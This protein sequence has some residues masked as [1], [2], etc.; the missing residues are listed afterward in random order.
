MAYGVKNIAMLTI[1]IALGALVLALVISARRPPAQQAPSEQTTSVRIITLK[2]EEFIPRVIG[3]GAVYPARTWNAVAQV[4]GRL[5]YVHPKFKRGNILKSG[6]EI[7][8]INPQDYELALRETLANIEAGKAKLN[9]LKVQQTNIN[10]SLVIERR[11]VDIKQ[12]ELSR[13]EGLVKRGTISAASIEVVQRELLAQRARVQDLENNLRL[14]PTQISAQEE[15]I[16]VFQAKSETARLNLKRTS[17]RLP[18]DA[19]IADGKAEATQF[20][21]VGTSLGSADGLDVAE[22]SAQIPLTQ[23]RKFVRLAMPQGFM[24]PNLNDQLFEGLVE[25]LGWT[26]RVRVGSA[27]DET[28]WKARFVRTSD[29]ID[30]NTRTLGAIVAVDQPY[31]NIRPGIRPPLVK[32]MFV[33]VEIE[34]RSLADQIIIPRSALHGGTVWIANKDNRLDIRPIQVKLIQGDHALIGSGITAGERLVIGDLSPAISGMLLKVVE[35]EQKNDVI[36][37]TDEVV[38]DTN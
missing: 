1:P 17:I 28:S 27:D 9:E 12:A 20:V 23:F 25:K 16:L 5:E 34:S 6:T 36:Q 35:V 37:K 7:L 15:Q 14:S 8:R 22:V 33:E 24:L 13:K 26:A 11:S 19:R 4:S 32:G 18:F 31:A 21:S 38:G 3:Y 2:K 10:Q 30:P 29:T